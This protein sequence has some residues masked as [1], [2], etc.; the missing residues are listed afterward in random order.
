VTAVT[1]HAGSIAKMV[2][3]TAY[4]QRR[5]GCS[6]APVIATTATPVAVQGSRSHA[7]RSTHRMARRSPRSGRTRALLRESS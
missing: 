1:G 6:C 4:R 3:V 5:T 2:E 7:I